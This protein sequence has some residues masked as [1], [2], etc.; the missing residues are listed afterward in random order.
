V[1]LQERSPEKLQQFFEAYGAPEAAAMCY[2]L[3]TAEN[4]S[5]VGGGSGC[6]KTSRVGM[7]L[8]QA[9][10]GSDSLVKII[11][12]VNLHICMLFRQCE[13]LRLELPTEGP[14]HFLDTLLNKSLLPLLNRFA[15]ALCCCRCPLM[16]LVRSG[17]LRRPSLRWRTRCWWASR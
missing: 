2:L 8:S 14:T 17:W 12:I 10:Y 13:P 4:Q 15:A 16:L 5:M 3:A 7:C 1:L 11:D 9:R 6:Y